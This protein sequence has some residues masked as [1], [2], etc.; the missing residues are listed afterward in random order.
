MT[1]TIGQ[2][3]D[4]ICEEK[5]LPK[6]KVIETIEAALAAAY[7]KDNQAK[8]KN[9]KVEF[10]DETGG[11]R[12]Y[13]EK[14]VV[15]DFDVEATEE[16]RTELREKREQALEEGDEDKALELE[17]EEK[18]LP[19]FHLK[20]EIML[21]EAKE[22]KK[23]AK[24]GDIIRTELPVTEEYG[25]MAAQTAKQ[26]IIQ[27]LRE[28]E[29]DIVFDEFKDYEGELIS[30]IIQRQE[31]GVILVDLN[32]TTGVMPL[33][34][35]VRSE[36]YRPGA[37]MQ[38]FVKEVRIGGK[39][40][41]VYLSRSHPEMI[42]KM[43]ELEVPE[44]TNEIVEIKS[45]ARE[46]GSRSKIAVFTD[47][48]N[49]DPVGSCVGQRG[50]RVQTV[51]NELG[52]EKI[53][54]IE[55]DEDL[56]VFI[57]HALSPAQIIK[58]DLDEEEKK[59]TVLVREDQLS[60]AIGKAGQNVRLAA[61]LTGWKIDIMSDSGTVMTSDGEAAEGEDK[62]VDAE[63]PTETVPED[64]EDT[65]E[66]AEEALEENTEEETAQNDTSEEESSDEEKK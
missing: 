11:T 61:K 24:I 41:E 21:S 27:R 49:I 48:E 1:S 12:V 63:T 44:I 22:Q 52:G 23:D 58:V 8:D 25:R 5:G 14:E 60:L 7:K 50:T 65:T 16:Q 33:S 46:A 29:R 57:A 51:I 6:D 30:G 35:A 45:I 20:S 39:G 54:I 56:S 10:N 18:E 4:Q 40:P 34:D 42:R 53:D 28:V 64:V 43:F 59:A 9:V 62:P 36:N 17:E 13:D 37:R 66:A 55:W 15:E 38:F 3:I 47:Q 2:A 26:V 31:G 32:R 19:R